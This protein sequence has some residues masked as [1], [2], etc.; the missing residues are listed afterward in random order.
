MHSLTLK[1]KADQRF[2]EQGLLVQ[3]S[4]TYVH[5]WIKSDKPRKRAQTGTLEPL[6]HRLD[7]RAGLGERG[8]EGIGKLGRSGLSQRNHISTECYSGKAVSSVRVFV[9]DRLSAL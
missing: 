2:L 4:A 1:V 3:M 9:K 5:I 7:S 6:S 8:L